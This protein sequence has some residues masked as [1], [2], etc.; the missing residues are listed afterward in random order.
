[1]LMHLRSLSALIPLINAAWLAP[2]P[3]L[4]I[5]VFLGSPPLSITHILGLLCFLFFVTALRLQVFT[6]FVAAFQFRHTTAVWCPSD[7]FIPHTHAML[8]T[9]ATPA[10]PAAPLL[11]LRGVEAPSCLKRRGDDAMSPACHI[12]SAAPCLTT[13]C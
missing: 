13:F 2:P 6:N 1:M 8:H 5:A 3:V 9:A 12:H 4:L 7:S 11:L 10:T